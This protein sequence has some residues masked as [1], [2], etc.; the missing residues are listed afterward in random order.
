VHTDTYANTHTYNRFAHSFWSK[1]LEIITQQCCALFLTYKP[2]P[3]ARHTTHK[4]TYTDTHTHIDTQHTQLTQTHTHTRILTHAQCGPGSGHQHCLRFPLPGLCCSSGRAP[5]PPPPPSGPPSTAR[6][7]AADLL[8]Q[9]R[10]WQPPAVAPH[11]QRYVCVVFLC[12]CVCV[13]LC[14]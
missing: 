2:T 14:G 11:G 13:R 12:L 3:S 9:L 8:R 10:L 4:H 6:R 5:S 7:T 1:P